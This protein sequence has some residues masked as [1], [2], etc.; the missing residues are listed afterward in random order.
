MQPVD[1]RDG[2]LKIVFDQ[3]RAGMQRDTVLVLLDMTEADVES[4]PE[5]KAQFDANWRRGRAQGAADAMD[6]LK[7]N[8]SKGDMVALSMYATAVGNPVE[9]PPDG[10]KLG[11]GVAKIVIGVNKGADRQRV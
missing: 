7:F 2:A 3:A 10:D 8:A 9:A 1:V 5:F 11:A 4:D 6:I